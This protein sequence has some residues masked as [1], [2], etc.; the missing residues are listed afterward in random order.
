MV[1]FPAVEHREPVA[2]GRGLQ[3]WTGGGHGFKQSARRGLPSQ[4]V[5]ESGSDYVYLISE[6]SRRY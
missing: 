3:Q 2:A 6:R 4:Q 5:L 1:S